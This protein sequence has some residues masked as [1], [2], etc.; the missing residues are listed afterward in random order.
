MKQILFVI[1]VLFTST[2]FAQN[3]I[4]LET[5]AYPAGIIPGVRFDFNI[6][7]N[8]YLTSRIGYN[9]TDRQDFGKNDNEE[10][11][12]PGFGIGYV[13]SDFISSDLS[14]HIRTDLWFMD[15]DW[16]D[17]QTICGTVSP[18]FEQDING[19]SEIII[20]QPTVG[21]EY[22]IPFSANLFL[23]PSLSIGYEINIKT[24]GR[25]VG[26]GAILLIGLSLG[27]RF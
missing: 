8:S 5:Q 18:C 20:L 17:S 14:V 25:E 26:E 19:T 6:G 1:S 23:K 22:N 3:S 24:K 4:Q 27:R 13:R 9:F 12:G 16:R 11:G 10:G 15:I 21:I 2:L 7:N